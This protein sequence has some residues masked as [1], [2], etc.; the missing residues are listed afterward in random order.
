MITY[1]KFNP[2]LL[3]QDNL[4]VAIFDFSMDTQR[5]KIIIYEVQNINYS[6]VSSKGRLSNI[7]LA[8]E[9]YQSI[10]N[11]LFGEQ[12]C[13]YNLKEGYK[14]SFYDYDIGC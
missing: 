5:N 9:E 4:L 8:R 13:I 10:L 6:Q 12:A 3:I 7:P 1:D 11:R 14:E 2:G